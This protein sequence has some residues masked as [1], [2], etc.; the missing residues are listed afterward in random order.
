MLRRLALL[1]PLLLVAGCDSNGG[2]A[3][4]VFEDEALL[5]PIQGFTQV[6]ATGTVGARDASDWRIG[7]AYVGIVS[8]LAL[9]TPNPVPRTGSV[10]LA[11]NVVGG[12]PGGLDVVVL[13]EDSLTGEITFRDLV[14]GQCRQA[15]ASTFCT[16]DLSARQIDYRNTGGLYRLVVLDGRG[17]A[18]YGDVR[19]DL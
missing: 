4:L 13:Q 15:T 5:S 8:V 10:A 7:P 16:F 1:L 17:I 6:S 19:V 12:V 18:S 9:P 3:Q 2:N 14:D 11:F